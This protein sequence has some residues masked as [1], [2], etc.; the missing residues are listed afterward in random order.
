LEFIEKILQTANSQPV[1]KK[2]HKSTKNQ[3]HGTDF[4]VNMLKEM[5]LFLKKKN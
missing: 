5:L 2:L 4:A 3:E 1:K